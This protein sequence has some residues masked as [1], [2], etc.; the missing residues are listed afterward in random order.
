MRILLTI[1]IVIVCA[2]LFPAEGSARNPFQPPAQQREAQ[3][4]STFSQ[5]TL[6]PDGVRETIQKAMSALTAWQL[7][8]RQAMVSYA[9]LIRENPRGGAFWS[10]LGLAFIYG[11]VH[12]LGPGHGKVFVVAYFLSRKASVGQA[13]I[14]GIMISFLHVFSAVTLVVLFYFIVRTGVMGSVDQA[15]RHLQSFSAALIAVVGLVLAWKSGRALFRNPVHE[16]PAPSGVQSG[17][18][19][20]FSLAL[21]VGLVPCPGAALILLFSISLDILSTGMLAMLCLASGLALTTGSFAVISHLARNTVGTLTAGISPGSRAYHL[22][23]LLGALLITL[24]GIVLFF[25]R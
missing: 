3:N 8:I 14:T 19:G 4:E 18:G 23:P 5:R 2:S 12:A 16:A 9:K 21:A 11:V 6:L 10:F 13:L 17:R 25:N 20:P 1:A 15:G 7:R 22:P 24:M